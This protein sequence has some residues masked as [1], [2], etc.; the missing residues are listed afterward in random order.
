MKIA[1]ETVTFS[2]RGETEFIDLT[3]KVR[4]IANRSGIRNGL[5]HVFACMH[6][7]CSAG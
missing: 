2:T 1:E 5:I 6:I 3:G 4:E 7:V